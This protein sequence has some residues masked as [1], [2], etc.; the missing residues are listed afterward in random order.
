MG[1]GTMKCFVED[2]CGY[3][4][5]DS[6]LAW[7]TAYDMCQGTLGEFDWTEYKYIP[8]DSPQQWFDYQLDQICPLREI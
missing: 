6:Q 7:L 2:S 5:N 3:L 8:A 4:A 1:S